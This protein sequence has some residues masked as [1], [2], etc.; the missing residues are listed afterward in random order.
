MVKKIIDIGIEGNDATGDAIRDAFS[1]TNE[2]FTELYAALGN[3][4]GL[5]FTGLVQ[6]PNTLVPNN[7]LITNGTGTTLLQKELVAGT[8]MN[9]DNSDPAQIVL[10]NTGGTVVSDHTP[11]LGGN[12]D[13]RGF[14]IYNLPDPAQYST[15]QG[16]LGVASQDNFVISK[17]FADQNYLNSS[18]DTATGP[19]EVPAGASGA[20][21]PQAQEVVGKAGGVANQMTGDLLLYQD[22]STSSD[23][24]TAATKNYVDTNAFTSQANFFVSINGDDYQPLV[25]ESK[26]GRAL[27]Y[28]FRSVARACA[29]AE[30]VQN[31]AGLELGPYQ[32]PV[33][34]NNGN[35]RSTV[36][37]VTQ[38]GVSDRYYLDITQGGVGT[39]PR[40]GVNYDIRAGLIF[41][42]TSSGAL[43]NIEYVGTVGAL[44][45]RYTINYLNEFEFVEGEELEYGEP[46]KSPQITIHIE[47]GEYYEHYPI[48]V[49]ENV[50]IVGDELRRVIIRP[51][52]G[53]SASK[54]ANLY[55]RRDT[56]F[57]SLPVATQN[58]GYHYLS[59][60]TT[61][62]YSKTV[63]N[64]GS[65]TNAQKILN[66]NRSFIQAETIGWTNSHFKSIITAS[67]D[68]T[69]TFTCV[70]NSMVNVGMP[71][72]FSPISTY[73][74]DT[75][76]DTNYITVLSTSGMIAGQT[77]TFSG[78]SIG[79][80]STS[81]PY[82]ILTVVNGTTITISESLLGPIVQLSA[83]ESGLMTVN[84]TNS[85]LGGVALNTTYYVK[86]KVGGT[87][88]SI[89]D[90]IDGTTPGATVQ[91]T[92]STA[93]TS[94]MQSTFTYNQSTCSRD[95]GLIIDAIGFD[96][97][98]GNYTKSLEA[99]ISYYSNAS[100]L[101]AIGNQLTQTTA[102][103]NYMLSIA[104]LVLAKSAVT[105]YQYTLSPIEQ[106]TVFDYSAEAGSSTAVN[107]LV[108]LMVDVIN[109]DPSVN[110]AKENNSIDVFLM[111]NATILRM[112]TCQGHG[113]FMA[114]LDPEGQIITK[115]PFIEIC[116]SFSRSINSQIFAGGLFVDGF[117][118]NLPA[119]I[120]SRVDDQ[121]FI[122][123]SDSFKIRKPLTPCSFYING[124]RFEV[125][126]ADTYNSS[127]GYITIYLNNN[128]P[129]TDAYTGIGSIVSNS[130]S[131]ELVAAGNRS[132]VTTHFTNIN[133]L[134]YALIATNNGLVEAVS[135]FTYY[136]YRAMYSLNGAQ[137]RSLNGSNSYGV[138]G[139]AAEGSDPTEVP[140]PANL[141]Y[142]MTQVAYSYKQSTFASSGNAGDLFLYV[143]NY[144][145]QPFNLSMLEIDH[146]GTVTQY[147]VTTV[148]T[149][150]VSGVLQLSIGTSGNS[151]T[152][153]SGLVA[154]V[155][156]GTPVVIRNLQYF[157][158]NN[159]LNTAPTRPSTALTFNGETDIYRILSYNLSGVPTQEAI[160]GS[161]T[162]YNYVKMIT[163]STAG[164]TAGSGQTGDTAARI[165]ELSAYDA[166]RVKGKTF[167]WGTATHTIVGYETPAQTGQTWGRI[168]FTPPL[169]KSLLNGT[170]TFS[171]STVSRVGPLTT[172]SVARQGPLPISTVSRVGTVVIQSVAR[173]GST[174]T[175]V[176]TTDHRYTTGD[177][178]TVSG[179][180]Y[181]G[182]DQTSVSITVVNTTTFT[183]TNAGSV[184]GTSTTPGTATASEAT[185]KATITTVSAHGLSTGNIITIS[186]TGV[187]NFDATSVTITSTGSNTFTYTNSGNSVGTTSATSGSVI[188]TASNIATIVT[189]AVHGL[190]T[191]NTVT[192][193]GTSTLGFDATAVT[194]TVVNTTTF[195]YTNAGATVATTF[196]SASVITSASN[197]ATVTTTTAHGLSA[198][199]YVTI[200]G[201]GVTG[202]DAT[203]ADILS[204]STY[205]FTYTNTGSNVS[206]TP[207]T[208]GLVYGYS[209]LTIRA[210]MNN[211]QSFAI[212]TVARNSSNVA[213]IVTSTAHGLTTGFTVNILGVTITGNSSPGFNAGAVSITVLSSTS[214]TYSNSGAALSTSTAITGVVQDTTQITVSTISRTNNVSTVTTSTPHNLVQGSTFSIVD[215][216][217]NLSISSTASS[218]NLITV[219]KNVSDGGSTYTTTLTNTG[220]LSGMPIVFSGSG[221]SGSNIVAG[222]TYYI[223]TIVGT[224]GFTISATPSTG[225]FTTFTLANTTGVSSAAA[226]YGF[227]ILNANVVKATTTYSFTYTNAGLA[228]SAVSFT[229]GRL[230]P[231]MAVNAL[232][233][234]YISLTRCTGHD[235]LQIGSGGFADTNYP[236]NI[237]GNPNNSP[238][239]AQEVQ[240]I[241]RGRCF[242]V[243]TDQFG[244]FRVGSFF[245]VDQG[246]G[247]VTFAA[248]IALSNLDGLGFK[249][250]VTVAEFSTDDS[251]TDNATDSV[252][253]QAAIRS[254]VDKRLGITQTNG[255]PVAVPIGPGFMPRNGSLAATANL[256]MGSYNI[257][258][259]SD[260][261]NLS[262][263]A[264]KNYVDT[265]RTYVDTFFKR[266]GGT[267]TGIDSF[268][269]SAA[270]N[271]VIDMNSNKILNVATPTSSTDAVN[272]SY[273][274]T[275]TASVNAIS[276]LTDTSITS[277]TSITISSFTSKSGT[278]P[279][280]VTFA[281]PSQTTAPSTGVGYTVSGNSNSSYNSTLNAT[282]STTTSITLSYGSD[283]GTYGTGVTVIT[284]NLIS[285]GDILTYNGT[286]WV[287]ASQAG[288][289]SSSFSSI[290]IS[291]ISRSNNIATVVTASSHGLNSG[292][293][294]VIYGTLLTNSV[295][296][297]FDTSATITRVDAVTFTY[298]DV[299]ANA[300]AIV[301]LTGTATATSGSGNYILL[302]STTGMS[303]GA[304]IVFSGSN[305]G[306][307]LANTPYWITG[308]TTQTAL[309]VCQISRSSSTVTVNIGGSPITLS[310][311]TSKLGTGPY[312]V[313]FGFATQ[314]APTLGS[315]IVLGNSNASY[316]GSFTATASTTTS[317]TLSYPTDPGIFGS[318]TTTA[319]YLSAHGLTTGQVVTIAGTG[320]VGV[321]QANVTVTVTNGT[322]FTF[323]SVSSGTIA[324]TIVIG[325]ATPQPQITVASSFGGSTLTQTTATGSMTYRAAAIGYVRIFSS[326]IN[327]GV[328]VDSMVNA[329]AAI[330]QSKLSLSKASAAA[331]ADLATYGISGFSSANFSVTAGGF[332]TL[333]SQGVSLS[334]LTTI[335]NNKVLGNTSGISNVVTG[336]DV[337]STNGNNTIVIRGNA[338]EIGIGALTTSGIT[339]SGAI[340]P[341]ANNTIN[342]GSSGAYWN[343]V[344]GNATS[345][346]YADLAENYEG[347]QEYEFGTV[348]MIGGEK[349]VT[350]A[351]GLGTTRV[352]GVVSENP[353]HLMN[354]GCSGIK[355]PV[356]LQ[357]RVPCKVVGKISKG[358][359]LI[360]GLI[361]GVA[362]IG[363]DPK[364][365]SIIGKALA[366]YDSD[367]IG[368]IEVLVGKH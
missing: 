66:S 57:D 5:T 19:I 353:A 242:Y 144:Q 279:Y 305:I 316:N 116:A 103:L 323:T 290:S 122:I 73:A 307:V 186:G 128:T 207:A 219:S 133:D 132:M 97:L 368:V 271:G 349:E 167:A 12:L 60:S 169:T 278:G 63:S 268:T 179:T 277:P 364:P 363:T 367:R 238:T 334:N 72:Q 359:L 311:F 236:S 336:I 335:A 77:I 141:Y 100:G 328:I 251:M 187:T 273:V 51:K 343:T 208:S 39:D 89:S 191:G 139:I 121:T 321:D 325:T 189:T 196:V 282:A 87:Q 192:I 216:D 81:I 176:T 344:Y 241:G 8:G 106:I 13:A 355:V 228:Q 314:T 297:G 20:E 354:A 177:L 151:N 120:S 166:S 65:F 252:P 149:T 262:D 303:A 234:V 78:T 197:I 34:Y 10:T 86:S 312:L 263:G 174:A 357:G 318:G 123:Q 294:V 157:R 347:D 211:I 304:P 140:T 9:I 156:D 185:P 292:D 248:S 24:L 301:A 270:T 200:S 143:T 125:D 175:I 193:S 52:T 341:N 126:Y 237:F 160:L 25:I 117:A 42:G 215:T 30:A 338:G 131:I 214:F 253:V 155:A 62:F 366:D 283:P 68:T 145:Y 231:V 313:T 134:G 188:T 202:F 50:S 293:K 55:F 226:G 35:D 108:Q 274:D 319:Q 137:I 298:T 152:A 249:R 2:N 64:A 67:D 281:I 340:I 135:I 342:L 54:W 230:Q 272:K 171:I 98:Y 194:V 85:L 225:A 221:I 247:T 205:S 222:T 16:Q 212:A 204:V 276:K 38:I 104:Q 289:I 79:G 361:P 136:C 309:P 261:S 275:S 229:L 70:S 287:N 315:Y 232:V 22:P 32:K 110:F 162:V 239:Q 153:T 164:L 173:S 182:F 90:T 299:G 260:P 284:T 142:P 56:I 296:T 246:T 114:V 76:S 362:M 45:E 256:N 93:G 21:A 267:R 181:A 170:G 168:T 111:N 285:N 320:V 350:I 82:Y 101:I 96:L 198:L 83:I 3:S 150:T 322:Q 84:L 26:K 295:Y 146:N 29:A 190:T 154:A 265:L 332:V 217:F 112:F 161:T 109:S 138:Y 88:F 351:K 329:S 356:A 71:I 250:G 324:G 206:S 41:R 220:L 92:A 95:I 105:S 4:G 360:V 172:L 7:I 199:N 310:S 178:V 243:S 1:K 184:V 286:S 163:D 352:A 280:L 302:S 118:G 113:G 288:S 195:T 99:A 348:V 333:S 46:V 158:F 218:G 317:I 244:N 27:A 17:K 49:P 107:G 203:G 223:K 183:Y 36:D 245:K 115:S 44:T 74:T 308:V 209:T 14:M 235:F 48:R 266:S 201:T 31:S 47:S 233:T 306:N 180:T 346:N 80:L 255:S 165:N 59:D 130:L 327:S 365:G 91:L 339:T 258:N 269:M 331:T 11:A 37:S 61:K 213:T 23:P 240:E 33:F 94:S 254:Y 224:T 330:A 257:I 28:A 264:N 69:D 147:E 358:D 227:G 148:S 337:S 345:A 129:D 300:T 127:T 6:T 75:D 119:T 18:G 159:V 259:L 40:K 58:Y 210:G 326:S 291:Q 43:A 15:I 53:I 124:I 102:A